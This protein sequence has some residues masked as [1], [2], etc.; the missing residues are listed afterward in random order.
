MQVSWARMRC[1]RCGC[2][3]SA[4][5]PAWASPVNPSQSPDTWPRVVQIVVTLFSGSGDASSRLRIDFRQFVGDGGSK[6]AGL[7][8]TGSPAQILVRIWTKG[9]SRLAERYCAATAMVKADTS[10]RAETKG[11]SHRQMDARDP[12]RGGR[13][14]T[15]DRDF[16]LPEGPPLPGE[17]PAAA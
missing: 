14:Y 7:R 4:M 17:V 10:S 11:H 2:D 16:V 12:G 1:G 6:V 13:S 15:A 9:R 5:S 8:G 3:S